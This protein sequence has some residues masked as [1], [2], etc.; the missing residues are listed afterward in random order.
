[1]SESTAPHQTAQTSDETDEQKLKGTRC[2]P[3]GTMM[4]E[5]PT[6]AAA[7]VVPAVVVVAAAEERERR[8]R[9]KRKQSEARRQ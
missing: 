9:G 4:T 7:V 8:G 1:M 6:A 5:R 3:T 2:L